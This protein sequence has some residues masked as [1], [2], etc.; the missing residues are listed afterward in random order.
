MAK[1][2]RRLVADEIDS[3]CAI[4]QG[5]AKLVAH[6]LSRLESDPL[7]FESLRVPDYLAEREDVRV[8][9]VKITHQAHDYR[10]IALYRRFEDDS[11]EVWLLSVFR[12]REGHP[13]LDLDLINDLIER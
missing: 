6:T 1:V 7:A 10:M 4:S 3:L 5:V 11:E 9:K 12:R 2:I 8:L 13:P